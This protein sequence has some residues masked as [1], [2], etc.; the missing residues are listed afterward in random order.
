MNIFFM[1]VL[2]ALAESLVSF[3]GGILAFLSQEKIKKFAH[4]VVSFAVGALLG[5]ALLELIP[6]AAEMASLEMIM[7]LV[8]FGILVFFVLEKF[9]FWYH[10]HDGRCPVHTYN[11]LILWGDF[12]HNFID[13]AIIALTFLA[14]VQLGILTTIAVIFHEIPQEI[15][16]FGILLHGGFSRGKALFYNFIISLGTIAG[17]LLA[18]VF[19]AYLQGYIPFTLAVIAGNFIY[20]AATD[21]MPELHEPNTKLYHSVVQIAL[22]ALGAVLVMLPEFLPLGI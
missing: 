4:F 17:A 3:S 8:L 9:L 13:G 19:G 15:G 1:I 18:Y 16:D 2:A 22:I 14:D 20:L 21:L 7:P 10:C 11:Y 6:E 5:V 12:L